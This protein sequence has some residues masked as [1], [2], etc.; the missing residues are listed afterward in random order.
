MINSLHIANFQS[1]KE[2]DLQFAPGLNV[3]LGQTDSGKTSILRALY[4]LFSNRPS[5]EAFRS[6]FAGKR[7]TLA[8]LD[9]DDWHIHRQ[10]GKEN[11]YLLRRA[12]QAMCEEYKALGKT[13]PEEIVKALNLT[14]LNWQMQ[15]DPPFLLSE[16]PGEVARRL[17]DIVNLGKIDS[18]MASLSSSIRENNQQLKAEEEAVAC[19][20][21]ELEEFEYLEKMEE[22]VAAVEVLEKK[23]MVLSEEHEE[24]KG[25][26]DKIGYQRGL[27]KSL[28]E[29][30]VHEEA[31]DALVELSKEVKAL[32]TEQRKLSQHIRNM[33]KQENYILLVSENLDEYQRE[34]DRLMPEVCPLCGRGD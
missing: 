1:H 6:T 33:Q 14:D 25:L 28:K 20:K 17:N 26:L 9:T 19:Q 32:W 7:E 30:L 12:G 18:S 2:S 5:G 27:V 13:V 4:W 10:R 24:I 29:E 22:D 11:M 23:W 3:I 21:E 31:V 34:F 15:L 16:S 8:I